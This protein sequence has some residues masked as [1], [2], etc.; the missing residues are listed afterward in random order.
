M[1]GK[2]PSPSCCTPAR[3]A[4]DDPKE[5]ADIDDLKASVGATRMVTIPGGMFE[6]GG[7]D[8]DG[9]SGDGEGPVRA[10]HVDTF[11]IDACAVT[12]ERFAEFAGSTGYVTDAERHGW[13][14]VFA[15]AVRPEAFG[16]IVEGALPHTPWWLAVR[17]ASWRHPEGRGSDWRDRPDHPVV[18]VSWNDAVAFARATGK[19][20]PT[21]A[22][23][24]KAARGGAAGQ[25]YPWGNDLEPGGEHRCNIWQGSFPVENL[26]LDGY[27]T[28]APVTAFEPNGFGLYN[29]VGNVWEWCCDGWSTDWHRPE[30]EATRFNPQGPENTGARVIRG[31]SYLCH[32]SYCNRYRLSA[33]SFNTPDSSTGNMGFRCAI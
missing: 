7:A 24:E 12:A 28:T 13:S 17:G 6:M 20:L 27:L 21:E 33:R 9:I 1:Q 19:R 2:K 29:M 8:P 10:V 22:E 14:F 25:R 3:A 16:S 4:G 32:K 26:G 5:A 15:S 23:W 31:G 11:G 30:S 18:H